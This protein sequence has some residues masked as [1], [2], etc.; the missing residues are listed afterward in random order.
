MM[1]IWKRYR[2]TRG[3]SGVVAMNPDPDYSMGK[4][5]WSKWIGVMGIE[6]FSLQVDGLSGVVTL[7]GN[8]GNPEEAGEWYSLGTINSD[9]N[10]VVAEKAVSFLRVNKT[11]HTTGTVI[12]ILTLES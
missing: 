5:G 11:T 12:C 2:G 9:G 1:G 6:R 8:N 4:E 7:E 3:A 10:L